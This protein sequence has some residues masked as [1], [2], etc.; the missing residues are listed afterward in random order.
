MKYIILIFFFFGVSLSACELE[1]ETRNASHELAISKV[2]Q[3][4]SD[5]CC[6][7]FCT[8]VCCTKIPATKNVS[9]L[10]DLFT[11]YTNFQAS[12]NHILSNKFYDHWQPPKVK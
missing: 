4:S 10:T 5:D 3:S 11:N 7:E 6:S 9:E 1:T 2:S 8:C 12:H